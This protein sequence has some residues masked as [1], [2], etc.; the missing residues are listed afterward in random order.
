M[1]KLGGVK[2]G[3]E[4]KGGANIERS[5]ILFIPFQVFRQAF[6]MESRQQVKCII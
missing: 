6:D 3:G 2:M 4:A 5:T 1:A